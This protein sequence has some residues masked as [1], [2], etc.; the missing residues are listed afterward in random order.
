MDLSGKRVL[1]AGGTGMTGSAV[2][3][4]V[5]TVAPDAR[6]RVPY[7][8]R[9][10]AFVEHPAV[11]Y[12][13]ADLREAADCTSV[14]AGCDCA[15][16][17]AA[18][19]GGARMAQSEP[20]KQ[21]TDNVVMDLRMLDAFHLAGVR[22]VVY[23]STATVYQEFDGFIRE[24]QLAL[25]EDPH[26]SYLGVGWAKRYIE[27]ACAFWHHSAGM[28]IVIARLANVFGPYAKFDPEASNFIAAT[29]RKAA[30]QA[31]PFEVW[32]SPE[33]V[34]DVVYADDVG[35]AIVKM[36]NTAEIT[37][38]VFN[39]GSG[40]MTKVGEVVDWCLDQAAHKPR[41]LRYK[42]DQPQTIRLRALDCSKAGRALGWA[43]T[44]G[45]EA[46]VRRTFDWWK[47]NRHTWRK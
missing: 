9:D 35:A 18:V 2:V 1:V 20:W 8:H 46:G 12:I 14:A 33:V 37:F 30:D 41:E 42:D 7:R 27:K 24:D 21:V 23:V 13:E 10:G 22:R 31:D 16:M 15:V 36:L 11:E 38:D 5:L 29:I 39:I 34:R 40:R 44:V 25:D 6:I 32:G 43:P 47:A 28:E 17:A 4:Q 3:R 26:P 19:T 45:I